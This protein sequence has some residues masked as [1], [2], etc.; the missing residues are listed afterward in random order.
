MKNNLFKQIIK[1]LV[2]GVLA[3]II[4]Y[5]IANIL[6]FYFNFSDYYAMMIAFGVAVIFNYILSSLWVFE[7]DNN[8]PKHTKFL[9][10]ILLS[11]IG[12]FL[13]YYI[14]EISKNILIFI[15]NQ[16]L[17]FNISKVIATSLVM[18]YNF[19]SRKILLERRGFNDKV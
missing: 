3:T 8:K 17:N 19:V 9:I 13:N 4:D 7:F 6:K 12:A 18:V 2:V 14:Y 10:F 1:F 15:P 5:L 11:I 16:V